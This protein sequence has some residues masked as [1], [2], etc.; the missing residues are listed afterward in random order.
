MLNIYIASSVV[1]AEVKCTIFFLEAP[2]KFKI[3]L[4]SLVFQIC[5]QLLALWAIGS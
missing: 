4:P 5:K 2:A 1:F 3:I